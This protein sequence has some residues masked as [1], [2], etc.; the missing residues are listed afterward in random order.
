MLTGICCVGGISCPWSPINSVPLQASR[1]E[2]FHDEPRNE[3]EMLQ[4]ASSDFLVSAERG[5]R[6]QDVFRVRS[7]GQHE[8]LH[9]LLGRFRKALCQ[10]EDFRYEPSDGPVDFPKV[11]ASSAS[12]EQ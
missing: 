5:G 12:V 3:V 9:Q 6:N 2:R 11:L 1:S 4:I 8:A 10:R 7:P